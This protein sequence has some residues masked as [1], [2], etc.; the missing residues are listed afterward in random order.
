MLS[1]PPNHKIKTYIRE[2]YARI[3]RAG[4][5]NLSRAPIASGENLARSL[6]YDTSRLPVPKDGWR[7]FAGCGNP[8]EEVNLEPDWTI[9]DLGCGVGVDSLVAAQSLQPPGRVVGVDITTELLR[10]AK[11]FAAEAFGL[12]CHYVAG[13]GECLPLSN[14]SVHLIIANGSFNLIPQKEQALVEMYRVL[15]PDG[16]LALADL[17]LVDEVGPITDGFE[18]AWAWCVAGALPV[19]DYDSILRSTGFSWWQVNTKTTYGPLASAH[20]V[21][22]KQ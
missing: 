9:L 14:E 13:D 19:S 1:S 22:R 17:I 16:C 10:L 4:D 15:R 12:R 8:L 3:A 20:I 5:A 11:N 21:A 18:N 7:L 2:L 6:G